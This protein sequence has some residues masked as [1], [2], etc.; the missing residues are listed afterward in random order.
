MLGATEMEAKTSKTLHSLLFD[1]GRELVNIKFFPG[2]DRGLTSSRLKEA[3]HK[4]L[5]SAIDGGLTNVPPS[6][7]RAAQTLDEFIAAR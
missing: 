3:A 1:E 5:R 4:A 7:G 6:C 2:S